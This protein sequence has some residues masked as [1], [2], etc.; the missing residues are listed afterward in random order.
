[1]KQVL[2]SFFLMLCLL[3]SLCAQDKELVLHRVYFEPVNHKTQ[4]DKELLS[5]I[6]DMLSSLITVIQPIINTEYKEAAKSVVTTTV[7]KGGSNQITVLVELKRGKENITSA[8]FSYPADKLNYAA[9]KGFIETTARKFS[10]HLGEVEPEVK[11]TSLIKDVETKDT[12]QA[13][14]FAEAMARPFELS[15]WVGSIL[16][17]NTSDIDEAKFTLRPRIQFPFPLEL[18]FV[19]YFERQQGLLISVYFDYNDYMFFGFDAVSPDDLPAASDNLIFLAGAG[20]VFRTLG[21]FSSSYSIS[22]L[23]GAV[24]VTAK[25]DLDNKNPEQLSLAAGESAWLFFAQIPLRI[26]FIYNISP[27]IAVQTN[28]SFVFNPHI[29]FG[30]IAGLELPYEGQGSAVQIQFISLGAAYRF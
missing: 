19:W 5:T 18:D 2:C 26:S 13:V 6:P 9:F 4:S 28:F 1:M 3:F 17:A 8:E 15:I 22:L 29:L 20:Y 23:A 11:I 30:L 12:I 25:Q 24:Q 7:T 27:N 10:S 21:V 14:Q 16:K